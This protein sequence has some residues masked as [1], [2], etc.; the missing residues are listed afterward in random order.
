ML[1]SAPGMSA[2]SASPSGHA[3][4]SSIRSAF[5][6]TGGLP[7]LPHSAREARLGGWV[8]RGPLSLPVKWDA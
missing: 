5:A 4:T 8:F 6:E 1:V 7:R 2:G 3:S